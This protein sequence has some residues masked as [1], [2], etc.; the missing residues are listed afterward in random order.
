L[1][2]SLAEQAGHY[3]PATLTAD[4]KRLRHDPEIW[5]TGMKPGQEE[6][7]LKQVLQAAPDMNIRMLSD[8]TVLTV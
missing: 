7:I 1:E 6:L 5:L 2:S 3:C 4:L 8:G